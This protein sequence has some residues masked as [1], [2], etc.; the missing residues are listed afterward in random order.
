MAG[1]LLVAFDGAAAGISFVGARRPCRAK[2]HEGIPDVHAFKVFKFLTSGL[3]NLNTNIISEAS[4]DSP[5]DFQD[6]LPKEG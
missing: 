1:I 6:R 5:R 2:S 3:R 4:D